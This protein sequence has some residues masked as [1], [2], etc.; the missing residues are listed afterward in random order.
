[1]NNLTV[2]VLTLAS[3]ILSGFGMNFI[4]AIQNNKK[5]KIRH[6][7]REHD[8]LVIELKDLQIKLYKI[9]QELYEW[10]DKYFDAIQELISV[11]A[12]LEQSLIKLTHINIHLN[13]D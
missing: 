1:M 5:E 12:E 2:I 3:A 7:E 10:K 8:H 13:E 4:L 9:E 11:K 6:Y